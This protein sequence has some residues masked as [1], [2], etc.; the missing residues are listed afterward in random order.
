MFALMDQQGKRQQHAKQL[1]AILVTGWQYIHTCLFCLRTR[2][3][4]KNAY[5]VKWWPYNSS[6]NNN[7]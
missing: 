7:Q 5:E 6:W 2:V 3:Q 1:C 4:I